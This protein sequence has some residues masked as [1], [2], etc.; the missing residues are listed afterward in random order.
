MTLDLEPK[1]MYH[2]HPY[3]FWESTHPWFT[4]PSGPIKYSILCPENAEVKCLLGVFQEQDLVNS[5]AL[6]LRH[7]TENII[8]PTNLGGNNCYLTRDFVA[9]LVSR[10]CREW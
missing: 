8:S 4:S 2:C 3:H 1:D 5:H 7:R 9:R 6:S 10:C